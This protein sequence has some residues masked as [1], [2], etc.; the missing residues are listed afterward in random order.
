MWHTGCLKKAKTKIK[1]MLNRISTTIRFAF[2]RKGYAAINIFGLAIGIAACL[3]ISYYVRYHRSYDLNVPDYSNTYRVTYQRWGENGDRV[4]F[5]SASPTIGP[6]MTKNFPEVLSFGRAYKVGGFFSS[7]E[8]VYDESNAFYG[9][10][11]LLQILGFNLL[12]GQSANCLDVANTVVISE[13]AAAKYFGE[14]NPVGKTLKW[15]GRT[16][17]EVTGV[18]QNRPPNVHFKVDILVSL[19]TWEQRAPEVF[20]SGWFYSGFYT[21]VRLKENSDPLGVNN[22]IEE[23]VSSE[24]GEVLREYKMGLSFKLQPLADIHLTSHF[25]HEL[26]SNNDKKSIALLEIVAW[27]ILAIAW[28]NFFNLST[29]ISFKRIKEIG[30]RKVNG[31]KRLNIIMQLLFES[32][33]INAV[34]L[35]VAFLLFELFYPAFSNLAGLP[36]EFSYSQN[37]WLFSVIGVAFVLGTFSAGIYSISGLT[38][39]SL[40]NSL[41]GLYS[42][43]KGNIFIKKSLVAFQFS[44]AIALLIAT[45]AVFQQYRVMQ[46][47]DIGFNLNN[48]LVVKVPLVGDSTLHSK[49]WVFKEVASKISEVEGVTYSSVV[50]GVP[51]M[52]NRGGIYRYGDDRN[53]AKNMRLTE[54]DNN[55][56]DVYGIRMIAGKGF[57]G[58]PSEDVNNVLLNLHGAKW[59]G[60]ESAESAVGSQIVLEGTPKTVAGVIFDFNQLS[61]KEEIEPQIFRYPQ[62]FQGYFTLRLSNPATKVMVDEV[63]NAY[64]SIFPGNP[65]E[66]FFLDD[67]YNSQYKDDKRFGLVFFLFSILAVIITVLGLMSLSAFSAEQ[68][69]KEIG[70]RKVLGARNTSIISLL[71]KGYFGLWLASGAI[72]IPVVWYFL[73]EWL[74]GFANRMEVQWWVFAIPMLVVLITAMLTVVLQS[75]RVASFNPVESIKYE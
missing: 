53:N 19:K 58:N 23:F 27:F 60:F 25:M 33:L 49:Y 5:A 64:L 35:V 22:K 72:A 52:F 9:E 31:A 28:V 67:F 3:Y 24:F 40:S 41:K 1:N 36:K 7:G 20:E 63:K 38:G 51:N 30:I 42:G 65:F 18:F 57:T 54:V 73:Q 75:L 37:L 14:T 21:Y 61:P 16:D 8:L 11:N 26:E 62:R 32:A 59:L 29:I 10:T 6:T 4:E 47:K 44:I 39:N 50:P 43:I 12:A 70:I 46:H 68:R 56:V 71:S 2:K 15:N 17:L 55:F 66:Y 34:A 45:I 69:R 13:K 74:N 48:M